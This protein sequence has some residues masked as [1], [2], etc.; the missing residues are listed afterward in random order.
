MQA[1]ISA[2]S[3][4]QQDLM[5]PSLGAAAGCFLFDTESGDLR[6][7]EFDLGEPRDEKQ[8]LRAAQ[9]LIDQRVEAVVVQE[10]ESATVDLLHQH[11]VD[12]Y[13]SPSATVEEAARTLQDGNLA[14]WRPEENPGFERS[15]T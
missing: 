8:Q 3:R 6:F 15:R 11:D 9:Q 10:M 14:R 2:K 13:F 1:A 7:S 4:S 12:V 5:A